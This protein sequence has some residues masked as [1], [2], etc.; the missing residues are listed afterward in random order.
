MSREERTQVEQRLSTITG[1]HIIITSQVDPALV[2]GIVVRSDGKLLDA[3]TRSRL[4]ALKKE[5]SQVPG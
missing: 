1:K 3:S 5:I 4:E 2:G